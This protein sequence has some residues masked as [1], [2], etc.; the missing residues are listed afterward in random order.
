MTLSR[1][2]P[3]ET[4]E[5]GQQEKLQLLLEALS[6]NRFY[7]ARLRAA[8]VSSGLVLSEFSN[9]I[10]FIVKQEIADDQRLH[11]PY[12]TNLSYPLQRYTRFCQTSGTSGSPIHW[13]DTPESWNWM[14]DC[15]MQV[16]Q[17]AGIGPPDRV[18]FAFSFAPFLG[19]WTAFEAAA[20]LGALSIPGGGLSSAAR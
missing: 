13:L 12:G 3:R 5:Q 18:F 1:F 15:W 20:K 9:R 2:Y 14:L 19:F 10:P 16:F 17:A 8:G 4:I 11:P 7:S 6:D